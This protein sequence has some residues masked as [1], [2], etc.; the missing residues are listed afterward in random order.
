MGGRVLLELDAVLLCLD[1]ELA[2]DSILDVA[3]G[4]VGSFI[5]PTGTYEQAQY[6]HS[7]FWLTFVFTI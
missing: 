3:D 2:T 7:L 6:L 1:G 4:G 5:Y